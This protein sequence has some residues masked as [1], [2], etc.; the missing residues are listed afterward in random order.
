VDGGQEEK[1]LLSKISCIAGKEVITLEKE[2]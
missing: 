1:L 2:G